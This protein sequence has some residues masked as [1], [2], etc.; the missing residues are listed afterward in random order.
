MLYGNPLDVADYFTGREVVVTGGSR[1]IGEMIAEGFVRAGASVHIT[2]RKADACRETAERLSALGR[3]SAIPADLAEDQGVEHLVAELKSRV[4]HLDVLVN[5]AGATWGAPLDSYPSSAFDKVLAVN[6]KALFT[7]TQAVLPLLEAAATR[8]CPARVVNIGSVD[9]LRVPASENYAYAASKAAVHHLSRQLAEHL[10]GR[11]I[12]VNAV[13]PGPF[14]SRMMSH[15]FEDPQA[16]EGLIRQ[17]PLGRVGEP[18]DIASLLLFLAGPGSTWL[19]GAI[20]PLDGGRSLR[21]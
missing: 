4:N 16:S 13:A 8:E 14:E 5:N 11:S 12:T 7:V 15:I 17:I 2:S 20:I 10:A 18:H 9:G 21:G 3:C 6:V 19:T 1:G